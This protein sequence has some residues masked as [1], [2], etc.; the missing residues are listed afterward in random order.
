MQLDDPTLNRIGKIPGAVEDDGVIVEFDRDR[1]QRLVVRVAGELDL[2]TSD[3]F[4]STVCDMV[5]SEPNTDVVID[6]SGVTFLDSSGIKALLSV[7]RGVQSR[8][9]ALTI[10]S[11][12]PLVLR[13]L[14]VAGLATLFGCNGAATTL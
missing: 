8:S 9:G 5:E 13:V 12:Q 10:T 11:P 14:E 7:R 1:M 6:M 3:R 2:G 4:T